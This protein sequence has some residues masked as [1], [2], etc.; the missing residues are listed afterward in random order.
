MILANTP[1]GKKGGYAN[2]EG[3]L[4]SFRAVA[5]ALQPSLTAN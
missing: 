2:I 1:F 3:G 5:A 4:L